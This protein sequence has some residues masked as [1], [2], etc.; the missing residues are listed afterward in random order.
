MSD[1]IRPEDILPDGHDFK[2]ISGIKVRKGTIAAAMKNV[3]LMESG[4]TKEAEA[5]KAA[6]IDLAPAL[7]VL[8]VH[9]HFICRN[10]TLEAIL[11]A[12][13]EKIGAE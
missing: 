8:G 9:K 12:A 7:V 11:T 3:E 2:I 1:G 13:A 10:S 6:L 5:A 4:N